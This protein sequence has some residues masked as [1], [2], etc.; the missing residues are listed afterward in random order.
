M[1]R[2]GQAESQHRRCESRQP[3]APPWVCVAKTCNP[4]A[5]EEILPASGHVGK[6]E[7]VGDGLSRWVCRRP[8]AAPKKSRYSNTVICRY[9]EKWSGMNPILRRTSF[10]SRTMSWS[11]S[12]TRAGDLLAVAHALSP[13]R[14]PVAA[15]LID[16]DVKLHPAPRPRREIHRLHDRSADGFLQ[17]APVLQNKLRVESARLGIRVEHRLNIE[18]PRAH[19]PIEAPSLFPD[20]QRAGKT[21]RDQ[22][23]KNDRENAEPKHAGRN[24]STAVPSVTMQIFEPLISRVRLKAAAAFQRSTMNH[25]QP[26]PACTHEGTR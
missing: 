7:H 5:G 13:A 10:R 14:I 11:M 3:R 15:G 2:P 18:T 25:P 16:E 12:S 9:I 20:L 26:L 22:R 17:P 23:E 24:Q 4:K 21:A 8:Y 6:R 19:P 1:W